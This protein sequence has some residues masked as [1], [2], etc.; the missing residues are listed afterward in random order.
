MNNKLHD[1]FRTNAPLINP[2]PQRTELPSPPQQYFGPEMGKDMLFNRYP[3]PPTS[4]PPFR[5]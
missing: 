5:R 2:E 1:Q 4:G 3:M